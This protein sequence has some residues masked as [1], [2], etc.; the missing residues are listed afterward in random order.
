MMKL[1]VGCGQHKPLVEFYGL[2]RGKCKVCVR[3]AMNARYHAKVTTPPRTFKVVRQTPEERFFKYVHKTESCWE[4]TGSKCQKGYG[5]FVLSRRTQIKAHRFSWQVVNG[6]IPK[7]LQLDHLCRNRGCVNP[8]HLEPVT[9]LENTL[10][11]A[12]FIAVHSRKTHC[13]NGHVFDENNTRVDIQNGRPRRVCRK[14][15]RF[16]SEKFKNRQYVARTDT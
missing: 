5:R 7:G 8:A 16:R 4:W 13:L 15:Q 14:C 12:N 9:N 1:C 3:A 10:R 2:G 11:G 6:E